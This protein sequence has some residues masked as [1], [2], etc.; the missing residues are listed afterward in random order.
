MNLLRKWFAR[1]PSKPRKFTFYTST[2]PAV[3]DR[4]EYTIKADSEEEA[5]N[6]LVRWFYGPVS[7]KFDEQV[8]QEHYDTTYPRLE[9][10]QTNMPTWF[11]RYIGAGRP[12]AEDRAAFNEYC[13]KH[14]I[15]TRD[16]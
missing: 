7:Y 14:G 12:T 13:Q 2:M 10:F 3:G 15:I 5:F 9:V 16:R 4:Y 1:K 8:E 6:I 11:A